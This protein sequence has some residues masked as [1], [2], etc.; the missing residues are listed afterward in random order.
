MARKPSLKLTRFTPA[1]PAD[2]IAATGAK[3]SG[4]LLLVPV[5]NLTVLPGFNVRATD[6]PEYEA[7]VEELKQSIIL[8]DFYESKPISGLAAVVD[9]QDTIVIIDG[10][11]RYAAV[12]A[13]IAEGKE[14]EYLPVVLKNKSNS[15]DVDLAVAVQ[16]ENQQTPLT[17]LERAILAERMIKSGMTVEEV[18]ERFGKTTRHIDDLRVL[19]E[20]PREVRE[21][22]KEGRLS[23]SQAVASIRRDPEGAAEKLL[24][25]DARAQ[26][27]ALLR[28]EK[29]AEK[30]TKAVVDGEGVRPP[31]MESSPFS[32]QVKAGEEFYIEDAAP[33]IPLLGDDWFK[34]ARSVK[35]RIATQAISIEGKVRREKAAAPA[36][37]V[38]EEEQVEEQPKKAKKRG[39]AVK[40]EPQEEYYDPALE[41]NSD[42]LGEGDQDN[43]DDAPDLAGLGIAD[44]ADARL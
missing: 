44:P 17:M 12:Q 42:D 21:L 13:A 11:L 43:L 6:T 32:F 38:E 10:H 34:N 1:A 5:D 27:R 40:A 36:A 3:K 26:E 4:K 39:K 29:K 25:A 16:K 41:E 19:V 33:Y 22:V 18:A 35:K 28:G 9:G 24:E 23:A 7:A 8:E 20:A 14:I 15:S 2:A 30:L 37:E 31:R